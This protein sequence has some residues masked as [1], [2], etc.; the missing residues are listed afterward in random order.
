VMNRDFVA[1]HPRDMLHSAFTK[2]QECECR[3]LPVLD[4]QQRLIG[5]LTADNVTEVLMIRQATRSARGAEIGTGDAVAA[6]RQRLT[7][8]TA[9]PAQGDDTIL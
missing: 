4:D 1:V 5:L 8:S 9:S 3:I 7:S 6:A 2:L